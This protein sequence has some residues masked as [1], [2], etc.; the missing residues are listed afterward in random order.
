MTDFTNHPPHGNNPTINPVAMAF[1]PIPDDP[2]FQPVM[3]QPTTPTNR[4][5]LWQ[6]M[7]DAY[8]E[9]FITGDGCTWTGRAAEIRAIAD[10]LVPE[11]EPEPL[12]LE[13]QVAWATRRNMRQRLLAEADRAEAGE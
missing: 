8:E 3:R 13:E 4:P 1:Y 5:P 9:A 10:W 6:V 11:E 12:P 7:H 2:H